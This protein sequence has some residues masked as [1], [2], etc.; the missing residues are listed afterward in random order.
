MKSR[1]ESFEKYLDKME[2]LEKYPDVKE[3]LDKTRKENAALSEQL[4]KARINLSNCEAR[5]VKFDG[6]EVSLKEVEEQQLAL[7]RK[8]YAEEIQRKAEE[9]FK[10]EAPQRTKNELEKLLKLPFSG[11]ISSAER[12]SNSKY[13]RRRKTKSAK[14][15]PVASMVQNSSP[16]QDRQRRKRRVRPDLLRRC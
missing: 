4:D 9:K 16:S 11:E 1:L 3:Q 8:L 10:A 2:A 5:R 14:R 6:R 7:V 13:S 12:D 15:I